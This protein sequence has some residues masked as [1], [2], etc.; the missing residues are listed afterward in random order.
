M[1]NIVSTADRRDLV[2]VT[3]TWRWEAFFKE[4]LT[5][6]QALQLEDDCARNGELMPTVLVLLND[7][8]PAGMIALC[9]DDLDDRPELNPWLAG[10]Y[11]DPLYRGRGYAA[12]LIRELEAFALRAGITQLS[13]YTSGAVGLYRKAGWS[14][15]ESFM[16]DGQE[17]AIMQKQ[18]AL[19]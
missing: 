18:L 12:H 15:V 11:V 4:E 17:Y 19:R 16:K 2:S 10:L 9:L 3:G 7:M 8:Q 1:L 5:Q 6:E 14:E 13:L